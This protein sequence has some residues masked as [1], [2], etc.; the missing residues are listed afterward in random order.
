MGIA[1]L[2]KL[3]RKHCPQIYED[4]HISEYSFKK[5]AIDISLYLCK[6][7]AI[8]GDSWLTAFVNLVSCLRKNEVHC[9]FIYDGIAT[10]DKDAEKKRRVDDRIKLTDQV[11]IL[12][13]A[14]EKY[15]R[16]NEI[17]KILIEFYKKSMTRVANQKR[18]MSKVKTDSTI[19]MNIVRDLIKKKRG[20]ILNI[21][22]DDFTLTKKLFDI[23][24]VPYYTAPTE[25]ETMCS[26]MCK[27][28]FVDAVL[29]EDTDVLAY[30]SPIFLNNINTT[31]GTCIRI[32][33]KEV[34][35]ELDLFNDEFLDVCIMCGTDYNSN[36]PGIGP[37]KAYKLIQQYSTIEDIAKN[38][39]M[40]IS[41]LNHVRC[42]QLFK[43][44]AKIP[45]FKVPYCGSPDFEILQ[46]FIVKY[47]VK[48]NISTLVKAFTMN[49]ITI[50]DDEDEDEEKVVKK[51]GKDEEKEKDEEETD[52][53][54]KSGKDEEQDD[55]DEEIIL[56]IED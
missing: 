12:E 40:D 42:R 15:D 33:Y 29:S 48:Y 17:D 41:I 24:K 34:L 21:T 56:E 37:E 26:H 31:N 6:F 43:E 49:T 16:T 22:A 28:G 2:N 20:Q 11:C 54:K 25:A 39:G 3:L 23:L 13:E 47:N 52:E 27:T 5:I 50:V 19:D 14:L 9:V 51:S 44:Y 30:G 46:E 53:V 8:C 35:E 38:T 4:I 55:S 1:N 32:K 18:L 45:D 36:M 7:K 10:S